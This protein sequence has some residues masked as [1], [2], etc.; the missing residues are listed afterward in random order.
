MITDF[1]SLD[2]IAGKWLGIE[3]PRG[4]PAPGRTTDLKNFKQS[5]S[6][7]YGCKPALGAGLQFSA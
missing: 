7:R 5:Y 6:H 4:F 2:A 3:M 1:V